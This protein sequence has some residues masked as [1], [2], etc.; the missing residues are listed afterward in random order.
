MSKLIKDCTLLNMIDFSDKKLFKKPAFKNNE[1]LRLINLRGFSEN[2]I[3]L[4]FLDY[5]KIYPGIGVCD[6]FYKSNSRMIN[7]F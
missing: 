4:K 3:S 5:K 6:G 7:K 1:N 2:C